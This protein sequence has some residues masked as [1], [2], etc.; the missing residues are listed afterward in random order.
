MPT[1]RYQLKLDPARLGPLSLLVLMLAPAPAA[2]LQPQTVSAFERQV[3]AAQQ[4]GAK[5]AAPFL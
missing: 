2:Q 5:S 3:A 4:A 1:R